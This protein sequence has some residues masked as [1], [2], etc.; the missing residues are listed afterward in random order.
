MNMDEPWNRAPYFHYNDRMCLHEK[1]HKYFIRM[2]SGMTFGI[3]ILVLSAACKFTAMEC[4]GDT[5]WLLAI[6]A[7]S[8]SYSAYKGYRRHKWSQEQTRLE[9]KRRLAW[10]D[11][12][13]DQIP[14]YQSGL[15]D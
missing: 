10:Y 13:R 7:M 15:E 11:D 8:F 3:S 5:S 6:V 14:P 2:L 1:K 12:T 4:K 9:S